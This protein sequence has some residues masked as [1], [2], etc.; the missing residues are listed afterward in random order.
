M[1][2]KRRLPVSENFRV[3]RHGPANIFWP[4]GAQNLR[5]KVGH[6][7]PIFHFIDSEFRFF[8]S[9]VCDLSIIFLWYYYNLSM[10]YNVVS[11]SWIRSLEIYQTVYRNETS[12]SSDFDLVYRTLIYRLLTYFFRLHQYYQSQIFLGTRVSTIETICIIQTRTNVSRHCKFWSGS[13]D[14]RE[15]K[16]SRTVTSYIGDGGEKWT[17]DLFSRLFC[18]P[19]QQIEIFQKDFLTCVL[20]LNITS[21]TNR[22]SSFYYA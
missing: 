1:S 22:Y 5:F 18:L 8:A 17:T 10:F 3:S 2:E 9:I 14:S 13:I 12:F 4:G 15:F 19:Y 11:I 7:L 21:K 6:G 20:E 16:I